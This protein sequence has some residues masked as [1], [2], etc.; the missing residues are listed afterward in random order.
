MDTNI[1]LDEMNKFASAVFGF[2]GDLKSV[3][4]RAGAVDYDVNTF[5]MLGALFTGDVRSTADRTAAGL[6]ALYR[7][8]Y[9]DATAVSDTALDVK[10]N[11]DTQTNRF[12]GGDDG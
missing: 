2:A 11:E 8:V 12:R 3:A 4:D 5:G 10:N 9:A 1:N 7:N 6:L